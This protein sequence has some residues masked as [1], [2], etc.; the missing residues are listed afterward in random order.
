MCQNTI[1]ISKLKLAM[2]K[3]KKQTNKKHQIEHEKL[4]FIQKC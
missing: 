1:T 2:Y 3:D 4:K